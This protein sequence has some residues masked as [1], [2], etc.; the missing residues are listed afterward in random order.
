MAGADIGHAASGNPRELFQNGLVPFPPVVRLPH[1]LDPFA[2]DQV[3]IYAA[4]LLPNVK[5]LML[6]WLLQEA[7]DDGRIEGVHMLPYLDKY[8]TILDG[9]EFPPLDP[10][11]LA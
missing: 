2:E 11:W 9:E 3:E 7:I 1:Y 6:R 8:S 4:P 10:R 5:A